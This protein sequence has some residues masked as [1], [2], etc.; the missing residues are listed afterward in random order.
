MFRK[1]ANAEIRMALRLAEAGVDVAEAR[2]ASQRGSPTPLGGTTGT[3][4]IRS[5][6]IID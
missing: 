1:R 3:I 2:G 5:L 4:R 6:D